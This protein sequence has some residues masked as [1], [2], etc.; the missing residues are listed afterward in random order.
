MSVEGVNVL[1]IVNE[2]AT[3]TDQEGEF[4]IL[5][6]ADDLLLITAVNLEINRRL[7]EE[8]DLKQETILIEMIPKV[9]ALKE[10]VINKYPKINA[11]AL[12]IIPKAIKE[13][14]WAERGRYSPP[15]NIID[16][17]K[18]K[19]TGKDPAKEKAILTEK[20][21]ALIKKLEFVFDEEYYVTNL[22]VQKD[23]IR[24]F[25][26]FCVEDPDF[27]RALESKNKA[28]NKFLLIALIVPLAVNYNQYF[29]CE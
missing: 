16:R 12:G 19:V 3:V 21:R 17:I 13:P 26:F 9:T 27:R 6:K 15:K 22:K 4:T 10:V 23:Y 14:T 1:N 24:G 7:I 8:E 25:Q 11:V 2:K 28:L 20:K 5:A 29:T 18:I